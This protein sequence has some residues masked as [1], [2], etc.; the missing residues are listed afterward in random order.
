MQW[1]HHN[2]W[3]LGDDFVAVVNNNLDHD[4]VPNATVEL[5]LSCAVMPPSTD[6]KD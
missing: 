3:Q 6:P 4:F 1:S 2:K 5:V